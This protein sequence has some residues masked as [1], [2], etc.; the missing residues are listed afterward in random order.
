MSIERVLHALGD[1]T[2]RTIIEMLS[3]GPQSV[4]GMAEPFSMSLAAVVQHLHILEECGL[5]KS[6]DG[7]ID[8]IY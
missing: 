6:P 2:R 1:P 3:Q 7:F 4:S 5:V 8:Q